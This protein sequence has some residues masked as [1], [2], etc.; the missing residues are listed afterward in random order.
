VDLEWGGPE[1]NRATM[2]RNADNIT[3]EDREYHSNNRGTG[4]LKPITSNKDIR[5]GRDHKPMSQGNG[6]L[7]WKGDIKKKKKN[8]CQEKAKWT[9]GSRL[10][11]K[12]QGVMRNLAREKKKKR[13]SSTK[14]ERLR[15]VA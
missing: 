12:I 2:E 1:D 9:Q 7:D 10:H 14:T 11:R 4:L 6:R 13:G 5:G 8:R 3:G 15:M